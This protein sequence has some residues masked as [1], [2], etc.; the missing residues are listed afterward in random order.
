MK[1]Y[2]S[3]SF[4]VKNYKMAYKMAVKI[5]EPKYTYFIIIARNA[6]NIVNVK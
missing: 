3:M 6:S 2:V 4:T 5:V 1:I